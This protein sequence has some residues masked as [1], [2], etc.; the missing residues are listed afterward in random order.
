L[1]EKS[2]DPNDPEKSIDP[3]DPEKSDGMSSQESIHHFDPLS[4]C[5]HSASNVA[6]VLASSNSLHS[7]YFVM[8]TLVSRTPFFGSR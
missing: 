2:I 8:V 3:N 6:M 1:V 4:E 7:G 5:C